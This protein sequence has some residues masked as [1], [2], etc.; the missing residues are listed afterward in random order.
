MSNKHQYITIEL[1]KPRKLR[2]TTNALCEL[3]DLFDK[4][5]HEILMDGAK[6]L[7]TVRAF[8]WAGLL[9]EDP[10]LTLKETGDL[11]DHKNDFLY[12]QQKVTEAID[13]AFGSDQGKNEEGPKTRENQS[14]TGKK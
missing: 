8:L 11:I 6:G 13:C 9:H 7:R 12:V 14:G 4:P 5:I 10:E 2:L 3:E 1:D